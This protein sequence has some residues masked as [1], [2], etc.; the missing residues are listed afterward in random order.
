MTVRITELLLDKY[1]SDSCSKEELKFVEEYLSSIEGKQHLDQY[2]DR[3][4]ENVLK[5]RVDETVLEV[6]RKMFLEE[7]EREKH[8]EDRNGKR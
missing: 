4:W 3:A 6:C 1:L 2:L 8:M 7:V 5:E